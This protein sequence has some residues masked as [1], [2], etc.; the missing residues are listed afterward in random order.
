MNK[1]LAYCLCWTLLCC[2]LP[3]FGVDLFAVEKQYWKP[4]ADEV[5]LQDKAE[6]VNSDK[7]LTSVAVQDAQVYVV[8]AGRI[9]TL[10]DGAF[11]AV[12][13]APAN[14]FKLLSLDKTLWALTENGLF[15]LSKGAWTCLDTQ[16][17]VDLCLHL[18]AVHGAT[19][20]DVFRLEGDA[21]TSIQPEGGYRSSDK[22]MTM[23]DGSQVLANPVRFGPIDHIA[24]YA[25]TLFA[26][27][28]GKLVLFDGRIVDQTAVDWG[29]LPSRAT[30]D[31]L[32]MGSRVFI[33]TDRG[34]AQYRGMALSTFTGDDGLPFEDTT[35]LAEGFEGELWIGT[36][37]GAIRM[38]G[39]DF[40]YFGASHWLPGDN[41]HDIAVGDQVV[42]VATDAGLGIIRYEPYTLA[43][44]A[45]YYERHINEW[46]HK[47]L[48][49]IHT[50]YWGGEERGWVREVSDNDGGHTAPWLAAMSFKYAVTGDVA[51]RQE[52][53]EAFQAMI[54]MDEITP[55]DGF[56][57]RSIFSKQGDTDTL[58]TQGSG[59][60][61]AKW[62]ETDDG[63]WVWKGDTSSDEIIAH[64]YAVSIFHD[65]AAKGP[66]KKRAA[67]HL[68]RIASH[69][70]DNGYKLIDMDGKPTRWGRWDPE[71]LQRP[72]GYYARGLNGMEVQSI[73]RAA[74][75]TTG[76][77]E[78]AAGFQ[79]L[80]DWGYHNHTVRQRI[81]FPPH[82]IAPWDDNL[83][84]RSY[85]TLMRYTDDPNL[86]SIYLRSIARTWE[87]KRLEHV[88]LF[89]IGYGAMTGHDCEMDKAIDH[90]RAWTLDC[91][92]HNY[93]NSHRSDLAT[94]NGY[95]AYTSSGTRGMSP[96]ETS[97][98]GGSR[99]A[100][101]Y[102]GG[103]GG[104]V[105]REPTGFIR[106]YWMAR[107][108]GM[109]EAPATT[110]PALLTV[111]PRKGPFGAKPYVGPD[112]P[113][114]LVLS[115]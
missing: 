108:H 64:I 39:D 90:L 2:A 76:K 14:V 59:G 57:A 96:R 87:I 53:V 51:V 26:L 80:L 7:P 61:P 60:L 43:K 98:Q 79:Q 101:G 28:P 58:A 110:D 49:F 15:R 20:D 68:G 97:V 56:I 65:L 77:E 6:K 5:Y 66:E 86:R 114:N 84:W 109:I 22:T 11:A 36:T 35:C 104:R 29:M 115:E 32:S 95:T 78:Y 8:M 105:V 16:R 74:W 25:G 48:G 1:L 46:G 45:A 34:L 85:Y 54:W 18:G 93:Q 81:V 30:R 88:S 69:V 70:I 55:K 21:M 37:R 47:R 42:Y 33:T 73:M 82:D 50:L 102:D 112:R 3:S 10:R 111:P 44:K 106:D 67:Q 9:M 17:Y 100:L 89:N 41:V 75:T 83:A 31:M 13:D 63:L 24:S 99:P 38:Q 92:E 19:R 103:R 4:A 27:R 113:K 23:A 40:Q 62:Y 94:E 52:A 71:Y 91:Q 12:A 72:Y 107:F